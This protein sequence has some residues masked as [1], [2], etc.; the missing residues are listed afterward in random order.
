MFVENIDQGTS[1]TINGND[2][3]HLTSALGFHES[4]EREHDLVLYPN[5]TKGQTSLYLYINRDE[6]VI[7]DLY[8]ADGRLLSSAQK[9]LT[10]GGHIFNISGLPPGIVA[11]CVTTDRSKKNHPVIKLK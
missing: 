11:V 5:P 9:N 8:L 2:V 3:L 10:K 6:Q 4:Y 1:M 7:I